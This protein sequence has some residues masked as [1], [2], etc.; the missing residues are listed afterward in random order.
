MLEMLVRNQVKDYARWRA[1]FDSETEAARS[2]GLEVKAI[3]R[4]YDDPNQVFFLFSVASLE[5]AKAYVSSSASAEAGKKAGVLHGEPHYV[6][7]TR[8]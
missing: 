4:D 5:R 7:R 2:A 8:I 6:D 1:V 3:W